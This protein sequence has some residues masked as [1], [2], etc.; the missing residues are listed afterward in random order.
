LINNFEG[1]HLNFSFEYPYVFILLLL[2][3]CFWRCPAGV[4]KFYFPKI[5]RLSLVRYVLAKDPLFHAA[6]FV[7]AVTALASPVV[8]DRLAASERHGRDLVLTID[9][10]GSMAESGFD[11]DRP[12]KRKYDVVVG[13]VKKFLKTRYDDNIGLVLFGSFAFAASA[14][15]Y[16]LPALEKVIDTTD[17]SIAG[18]NTAI[19]EG[20]DQALR[21]LSFSHA[22]R[23]VIVLIT[24]GYQNAGSVSIRDA[25]E[26]AKKRGVKIYTIGTGKRGDYD[27]GLLKKIASETGGKSFSASSAQDLGVVFKELDRL[28]PSPIRSHTMINRKPLYQ[29]PLVIAIMLLVFYMASRRKQE[30][31]K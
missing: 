29:W 8:Y 20:I 28:E 10:S 14:V 22:K 16:D 18:Q 23:K 19:G 24:D 21:A 26:K 25:V 5:S 9:T 30:A 15:T 31:A 12:K 11:K 6:V 3:P 17:V 2:L 13:I 1:N 27:A 4:M 7:V